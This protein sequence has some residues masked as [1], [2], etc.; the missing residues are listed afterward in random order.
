VEDVLKE[1]DLSKVRRLLDDDSFLHETANELLQQ[2]RESIHGLFAAMEAL[3]HL[4]SCL[5]SKAGVTMWSKLYIQ[6]LSGE[7]VD[8]TLTRELLLSARKIPSDAMA[9]LLNRLSS[10]LY[11]DLTH[12]RNSLTALLASQ[13]GTQ[14]PLRSEHDI[15]HQT[16]RTTVV[17]QKVELSK[18]KAA[19]SKEDTEYS[20]IVTRVSAAL[21][22]F[23]EKHLIHPKNLCFHEI[24]LFD[25]RTPCRDVFAPHPQAAIERALSVPHDYLGCECCD[26][27]SELSPMQPPTAILYQLYLESGALINIAD[28]WSA[29]NAIL[30]SEP[31]EGDE[32]EEDKE[33]QVLYG[34]MSY[35]FK[36]CRKPLA[37]L[38]SS[39]LFYRAL[40]ELKYLGMIKNSTK[41]ADHLV[42]LM[43]EG[44]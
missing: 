8:S 26:A 13:D 15:S 33:E 42:K 7:L 31:G 14:R 18:H 37:N 19:L 1:G 9:E 32:E 25:L 16:L 27:K 2:G 22:T 30:G 6:G 39:A 34:P 12:E 4:Q 29:F 5:A 11:L 44:L 24:F 28:L 10:T 36:L 17:A 38:L 41:K 21:K 43:W 3:R 35:Y 20:A 40:A 23:F